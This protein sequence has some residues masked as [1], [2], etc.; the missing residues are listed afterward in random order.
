VAG[1]ADADEAGETDSAREAEAIV[2]A[3]SDAPGPE[4]AAGSGEPGSAEL[5][6]IP[7]AGPEPGSTG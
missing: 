2:A 1:G 6:A 7:A 3:G 5:G 4:P